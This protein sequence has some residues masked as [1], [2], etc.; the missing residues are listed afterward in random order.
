MRAQLLGTL[1]GVPRGLACLLN[2]KAASILNV[3]NAYKDKLD[4]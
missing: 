4:N 1:Q 3:L 2:A